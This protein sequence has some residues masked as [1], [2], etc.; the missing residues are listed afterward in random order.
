MPTRLSTYKRA[1]NPL[2]IRRFKYYIPLLDL[3]EK[4]RFIN[5]K[6]IIALSQSNRGNTYTKLKKLF[7][8]N[9][10]DRYFLPSFKKKES[11]VYTLT[12]RGVETLRQLHPDRFRKI[13]YPKRKRSFLFV[14]HSLM[15]SNFHGTLELALSQKNSCLTKWYQ[16]K[17][18]IK[19]FSKLQ[20][21]RLIPDSYFVIQTKQDEQHYFL[22]AD[23]GTM[24]LTRFYEKIRRYRKFFQTNRKDLPS[25][26]RV[27]ILATTPKRAENLRTVTIT[28]DPQGKGSER[29][30][31][32]NE[33]QFSLE[34]P[35][36]LLKSICTVG[37]K[38]KEKLE[39]L[40]Q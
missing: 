1:N 21:I 37:L 30:L 12:I 13:Y 16:E 39:S 25:R 14:L 36:K 17:E 15:I 18:V 38:G 22:E 34:N 27:L 20:N 7:H 10:I 2:R 40:L 26:F 8:N 5:S 9:F 35:D 28:G 31:F 23:R 19:K 3:I 32:L 29:F 33:T 24:T 11:I 4:Y 6:Q